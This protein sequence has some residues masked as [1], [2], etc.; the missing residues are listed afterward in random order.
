[1]FM[2]QRI[3]IGRA[4]NAPSNLDAFRHPVMARRVA[5]AGDSIGREA[6]VAPTVA[7]VSAENEN[8]PERGC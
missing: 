1:M 3:S 6:L 5:R 8:S 4:T 2:P 7:A